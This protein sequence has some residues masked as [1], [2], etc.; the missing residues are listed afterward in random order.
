MDTATAFAKFQ[1]G[2]LTLAQVTE[3]AE[4][5]ARTQVEAENVARN[6]TADSLTIHTDI[7]A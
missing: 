7:R 3:I 2:E 1:A 6:G 5:N 4:A